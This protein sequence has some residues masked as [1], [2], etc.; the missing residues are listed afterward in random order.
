MLE[1]SF[2]AAAFGLLAVFSSSGLLADTDSGHPAGDLSAPSSEKVVTETA[3]P[4][5]GNKDADLG[6]LAE[7]L[8]NPMSDLWF[9]AIQNDTTSYKGDFDGGSSRTYNNFKIQPVMSFALT[10]DYNMIVRPVFQYQS[11]DYPNISLNDTTPPIT[12][13][14]FGLD[15]DRVDGMGDTIL[16]TSFGSSKPEGGFIFAAGAT[17]MFDTASDDELAIL[18]QNKWAVGPSLIGVYVGEKWIAGAVAQHWWGQGDKTQKLRVNVPANGSQLDL[19]VD[20]D[21]LNLTDIQ[22]ILRYRYSD[23][24]N[25]GMG[26]NISINWNESGSDRYTIPVGLGFD[27]MAMFGPLPV[28][29]GAELHYYANQPDA[30]GPE[31]N[32]RVFFVPIVPNPFK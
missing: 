10:D 8:N 15:F 5:G 11:Y 21:D 16:M 20:G 14:S 32:L 30:F 25:I 22:Y 2:K 24:T 13:D 9:L 26:P 23:E 1:L 31:W 19:E 29:W 27:T 28:K 4:S 7:E 6:T 17:F 3:N 12:E 18:Q